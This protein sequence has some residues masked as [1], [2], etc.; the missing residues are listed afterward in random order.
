MVMQNDN[1]SM[2]D[3]LRQMKSD[4]ECLKADMDKQLIVNR[5]LMEMVLR[6]NVGVLDSNRKTVIT[7][8]S[9]AILIILVASYIKGLDMCLAG[10]IA[11]LYV[12]MLIGYVLIY[13]RLGKIEYGTDDVLSTVTRLRK[14]RRNYMLVNAVSWV[15]VLGL[16][17]FIF[18]EIYNSFLIQKQGIAAIAFMCVAVVAGICLQYF[19]DRKVLRTCDNIIDHLKERP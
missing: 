19:V 16:M 18:P 2:N 6:N 5:Q 13:R 3:E 1:L 12:L 14:F 11:A 17:C 10:V 7:S 9:A 15:L 8:I 4:Y